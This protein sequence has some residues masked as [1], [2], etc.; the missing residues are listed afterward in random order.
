WFVPA[1]FVIGMLGALCGI[2][3]GIL[4]GPLLHAVRKVPLKRAAASAILVV[5]ATTL[6]ATTA[7]FFRPDS[8]LRGSVV[9]PLALGAL[10]GA[11][12]G[13]ALSRRIDE[14]ALKRV[15]ALVLALAALRVLFFTSSL[16]PP[17]ALAGRATSALALAIGLAGGL[18]TPL[19]GVAGG[20]LMVPA[21]FLFR[22]QPFGVARACALAAGSVSALLSLWLHV[23]AGNVSTSLGL[24]VAGGALFGALVGVVA[25]H[26]PLLAPL[27]R[28]LLGVVLL[29][30][31]GRF[32]FEL[33][34]AA[35]SEP[36]RG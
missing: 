3:G 20:V 33:R 13:F 34:R 11:R 8:A 14:R 23:R 25:A 22:G 19:L 35:S 26:D 10:L 18:L 32:F 9:L 21:L 2:G 15:F 28:V 27:G 29:A 30:Q 6:A 36:A 16:T 5:L 12:L 1:G 31:A 24:L 17:D 7:E 4:A